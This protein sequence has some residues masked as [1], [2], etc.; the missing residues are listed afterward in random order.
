MKNILLGIAGAVVIIFLLIKVMQPSIEG[1]WIADYVIDNE[2]DTLNINAGL[3]Q[4]TIKDDH[5]KFRSTLKQEEQGVIKKEG[6][7][8]IVNASNGIPAYKMHISMLSNSHMTLVMN[9][10]EMPQKLFLRR[11]D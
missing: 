3:V 9:S 5:Y 10:G 11:S 2:T 7:Q 1:K 8:L 6:N 4:L